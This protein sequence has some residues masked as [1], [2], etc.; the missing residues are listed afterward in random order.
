MDGYI[1]LYELPDVTDPEAYFDE[2]ERLIATPSQYD[3]TGQ[4]FT[5]WHKI[6][7]RRGRN[8]V[9]HRVAFDV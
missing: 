5:M 4:A 1:E 9:Y 7:K 6:I 3:C 2:N 8:M